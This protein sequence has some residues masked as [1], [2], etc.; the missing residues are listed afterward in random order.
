[1]IWFLAHSGI[2]PEVLGILPSFL[3][4]IDPRPAAEQIAEKYCG[5]WDALKGF[6]RDAES[7]ALGYA[8][9]PPMLPVAVT[10]LRDERIY[11]YEYGWTCI[12]QPDG[13]F[14]VARLS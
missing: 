1:M 12:V 5:G 3:S 6:T 10:T 11:L 2:S 9:D 4:S 13:S 7:L 14:E 8:G